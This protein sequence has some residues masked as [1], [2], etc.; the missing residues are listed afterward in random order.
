[1]QGLL[2]FIG[3]T[4]NG[5]LFLVFLVLVIDLIIRK[6]AEKS[7]KDI[8]EI[9]AGPVLRDATSM[10]LSVVRKIIP[11]EE[12]KI[13]QIVSIAAL[14]ALMLLLKIFIIS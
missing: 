8:T 11:V 12:D 2:N 9:P 10:I 5:I 14:I 7:G 1:M 4:I 6:T 13:L 3:Q